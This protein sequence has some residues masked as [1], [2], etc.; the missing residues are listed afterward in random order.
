LKPPTYIKEYFVSPNWQ[1]EFKYELNML[2]ANIASQSQLDY[3]ALQYVVSA[4]KEIA[5]KPNELET[6]DSVDDLNDTKQSKSFSE[7]KKLKN[8]KK[9]I[10]QIFD[11]I[12]KSHINTRLWLNAR[13]AFVSIMTNQ[14]S[15]LGEYPTYLKQTDILHSAFQFQNRQSK[16]CRY[17]YIER[18]WRAEILLGQRTRGVSQVP[19]L[20]IQSLLFIPECIARATAVE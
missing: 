11:L 16:R 9:G 3:M 6:V 13:Q 18:L 10:Y 17:E 19:G 7:T 12:S 14:L 1:C 8:R 2:M 20:G 5:E 4:M 15:D